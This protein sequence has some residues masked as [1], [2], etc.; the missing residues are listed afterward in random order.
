MSSPL[1]FSED[2]FRQPV[3]P[4]FNMTSRILECPGDPPSAPPGPPSP[5]G[6][7]HLAGLAV[8]KSRANFF[9]YKLVQDQINLTLFRS[10]AQFYSELFRPQIPPDP[11]PS[12][13]LAVLPVRGTGALL[14]LLL[15]QAGGG[16]QL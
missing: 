9:R 4:H 2:S 7:Q 5:P 12:E 13:G 3:L 1:R 16:S 15:P 6:L 8:I 11:S 10:I 14:R